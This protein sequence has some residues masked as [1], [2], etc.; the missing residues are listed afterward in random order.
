MDNG[1]VMLLPRA[2][3]AARGE[4][5]INFCV[6]KKA[7]DLAKDKGV[8]LV[9]TFHASLHTRVYYTTLRNRLVSGL[10]NN[11]TTEGLAIVLNE[12]RDELLLGT[13][14]H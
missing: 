5:M 13:F 1:F 4:A 10:A 7:V 11:P 3:L 9:G 14:S 6:E 8:T 2:G 12:I